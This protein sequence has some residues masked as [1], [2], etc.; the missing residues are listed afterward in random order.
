MSEEY[1]GVPITVLPPG[2]IPKNRNCWRGRVNQAP[3]AN[4]SDEWSAPP[5]SWPLRT[6]IEKERQLDSPEIGP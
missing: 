5:P 2:P 4:L 1:D 6:L 3:L